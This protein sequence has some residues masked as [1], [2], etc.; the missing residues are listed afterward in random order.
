MSRLALRA[1]HYSEGKTELVGLL[2]FMFR[3]FI[4]YYLVLFAPVHRIAFCCFEK[5]CQ[6]T[7]N[8]IKSRLTLTLIIFQWIYEYF[9]I[10]KT[11]YLL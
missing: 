1:V 3:I 2:L 8:E 10:S 9:L 4:Q 5:Y 11:I 6:N 7:V